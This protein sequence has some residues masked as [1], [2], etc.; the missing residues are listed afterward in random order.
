MAK[1]EQTNTPGIFR[2]HAKD[3][4]RR[5]RCDCSYVITFRDR[6]RQHTETFRTFAEAR[7]A[8]RT[9]GSQ[10]A[11]GEFSALA[12]VTLHDYAWSGSTA[13]K[14]PA[15]AGS[16]RRHAPSTGRLLERFALRTS[17]RRRGCRRSTRGWWPTSSA[18]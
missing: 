15:A 7:E 10:V 4:G 2:R 8:K 5:G 13:T 17:R 3:C 11:R 18:G 1:L 12:K 6:G 9:R 14:A 16:A